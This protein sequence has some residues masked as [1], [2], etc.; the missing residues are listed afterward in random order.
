M[1][2]DLGKRLEELRKKNNFDKESLSK[3]LS[4]RRKDVENWEKGSDSPDG[5]QLI[6]LS[7]IYQMPIDEILLNFDTDTDSGFGADNENRRA[8]GYTRTMKT[9]KT[10][11]T[12][13]TTG[14]ET[15][16][17][18]QTAAYNSKPSYNWYMFPYPIIV[19]FAFVLIGFLFDTWHPTWLLFLTIPV[20]YQ[21]VTVNRAKTFRRKA[22]IFP[23]PILCV[24]F[25]LTIG[26]DYNLWHPMWLIF[27]TIPVYYMIVNGFK[28]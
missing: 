22:N 16:R 18:G 15:A 11:G 8:G 24:L 21:L 14:T 3:R 17:T 12:T 6:K 7:H 20:Y 27:L 13:G 4:V 28:K 2:K 25:Y 26:F 1:S 19:V 10:A 9:V 23:Y 5:E